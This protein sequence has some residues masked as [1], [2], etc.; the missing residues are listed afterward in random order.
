[1]IFKFNLTCTLKGGN[2]EFFEVPDPSRNQLRTKKELDREVPLL[3]PYVIIEASNDCSRKDDLPPQSCSG[4]PI[5]ESQYFNVSINVIVFHQSIEILNISLYSKQVLDA[6]DCKPEYQTPLSGGIT[7]GDKKGKTVF[8][9]TV[10]M[11]NDTKFAFA[12]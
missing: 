6:Y 5:S 8:T 7:A 2:S 10:R 12:V 11:F 4:I 1:M 9:L 3:V